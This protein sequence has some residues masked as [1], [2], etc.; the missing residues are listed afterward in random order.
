[1]SYY[2]YLCGYIVLQANNDQAKQ[3]AVADALREIS[4]LPAT[5]DG[6]DWP[7]L[8]SSMFSHTR[9]PEYRDAVIH[10]AASY[11][12]ILGSW[13]EWSMKFESL[14][15]RLPLKKA[16]VIV[17]DEYLGDFVATW[18]S[19]TLPRTKSLLYIEACEIPAGLVG[20]ANLSSQW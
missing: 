12:D 2:S 7:F 9:S 19:G 16:K 1:M 5:S 14:L 10:F 4:A 6:D 15:L 17:Q 13:E 20:L 3:E 11:K 18:S 8:S